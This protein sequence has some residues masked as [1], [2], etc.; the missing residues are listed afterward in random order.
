MATDANDTG[1]E[2]RTHAYL[3]AIRTAVRELHDSANVENVY[4]DP[5]TI[6][7]KTVVPV[8]R[9]AYG[10]GGGFGVGGSE[11]GTDGAGGEGESAGEGGGRGQGQ[12]QG[13]GGGGGGVSA[14]PVGAL[15]ITEDGTRFVRFADNGCLIVAAGVGLLLGILLGRR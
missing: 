15:E 3:E 5:I 14:R 2:E 1:A 11:T 9:I 13:Q 7:G 6:D 4:G 8:A 10:F 12:G